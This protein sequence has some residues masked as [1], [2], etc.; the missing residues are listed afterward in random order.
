MSITFSKLARL[1]ACA[2][3]E[4]LPQVFSPP[5][6]HADRGNAIHAYLCKRSQGALKADALAAVPL[7]WRDLCAALP[8]V[9]PGTAEMAFAWNYETGAVRVLGEDIGRDYKLEEGEIAG[10]ADL[11]GIDCNA[12]RAEVTDYKA[13]FLDVEPARTNLQLGALAMCVAK[14]ADVSAVLVR[15]RKITESGEFIDNEHELDAFDLAGIES[16]LREIL[17]H[18]RTAQRIVR[19]G[20]TPNVVE[21][22]HCRWCPAKLAC[23]A[24]VSALVQLRTPGGL[25]QK[26]E[27]LLGEAPAQALAAYEAAEEAMKTIRAQLYAYAR[28]NPIALPDGQ[29]FGPVSTTREQ[30]DASVAWPVLLELGSQVSADAIEAKTSKAAIERAIAKHGHAERK[31]EVFGRL[32]DVGAFLSKTTEAITKHREKTK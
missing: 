11:V 29:V 32:R 15:I 25:S 24:K 16:E 17:K 18:V 22:E 28:E 12:A 14:V 9:S 3:S 5:S 7:E 21:G 2:A 20:G 10:T 6:E 19:A 13:G 30:V 23:P 4:A 26:F 27:A 8:E 31:K 1:R